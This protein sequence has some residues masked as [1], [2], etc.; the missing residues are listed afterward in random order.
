MLLS[1]LMYAGCGGG[2]GGGTPS[3]G[4]IQGTV[5]IQ[6]DTSGSFNI[7]SSNSAANFPK[8]SLRKSQFTQQSVTNEKIVKLRPDLNDSE[9]AQIIAGLGG[10]I[11][12]KLYGTESTYLITV[13]DQTFSKSS[14]SQNSNIVYV[15]DNLKF[16]AFAVPSDP[17]Y[18]LWNYDMINLPAAW[19]E[20]KGNSNVVVAVIDS[21]VSRSHP[22]LN[23]NLVPGYDFVDGDSDP[24]DTEYVEDVKVSHGTHVAGT[25]SAVTNNGIGIAGIAWNVKIMPIRVLGSDG[26]GNAVNII[27]GINWAVNNGANVIN[28]SL[29]LTGPKP[30]D[31]GTETFMEA[32]DKAIAKGV[33]VVAAAGN[34][35]IST[36]A[37]P[38]NY[39]PVIAVSAIDH[40]GVKASYSNYGPEIDLCAPGGKGEPIDSPITQMI[41]STTYDK[42]N[43][44]DTYVFMSGTSMAAPHVTG[45]VALLY[46][47]GF[48][49]PSAIEERLK[50][51]ALYLGDNPPYYGAGKIDA[52]AALNG[53]K[54][55]LAAAKVY[56]Y[57]VD[58]GTESIFY[59]VQINGNYTIPKVKPGK[60]IVCAFIDK[61]KNEKI[62]NGD[63]S[64]ISD[65]ITVNAGSTTTVNFVL[66]EYTDA[67][68]V[69]VKEHF[70]SLLSSKN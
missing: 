5:S 39:P 19:D 15:E 29:G 57:N 49:V 51:T 31:S 30:G 11:K 67:S 18:P 70:Q 1:V 26:K 6:S 22:D 58:T 23:A 40:T 46:S 34:D 3:T 59:N 36:V 17:Y 54:Y 33:T 53:A 65:I 63:L 28:L 12:K 69:T 10:T 24:S 43:K 50:S 60:Y 61:D 25:I 66:E 68:S 32:I 14:A 41:L 21:G 44:K 20:Q 55:G 48:T 38:A 52:Y 13:N 27:E 45:V 64:G 47:R 62:S 42:L 7:S 9:V 35:G 4:T 2:G 16:Q 56:Y 37:F 8:V